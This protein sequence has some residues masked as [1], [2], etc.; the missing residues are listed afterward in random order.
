MQE[1]RTV[2]TLRRKR[3]EISASIRMYEKKIAQARADLAHV[4]AA[5]LMFEASDRPI[6]LSTLTTAG[7]SSGASLGRI[8]KMNK[9]ATS[10]E[11]RECFDFGRSHG[12]GKRSQ[13]TR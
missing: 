11:G 1:T 13:Q 6:S 5:I 4:A 10:S 3:D 2:T 7:Y 9:V 12:R 8:I